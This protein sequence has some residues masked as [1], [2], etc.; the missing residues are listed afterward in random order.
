[1]NVMKKNKTVTQIPETPPQ[2]FPVKKYTAAAFLFFIIAGLIAA[3]PGS[4]VSPSFH[5][6][7]FPSKSIGYI[8]DGAVIPLADGDYNLFMPEQGTFVNG[9]APMMMIETGDGIFP[10]NIAD[11]S[12]LPR[13]GKMIPSRILFGF[14]SPHASNTLH[15]DEKKSGDAAADFQRRAFYYLHVKD[16][17]GHVERVYKS[18]H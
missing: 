16:G 11:D 17:F 7:I 15:Y 8:K 13:S 5:P 9:V 12:I 18:W 3:Y 4:G 2:P 1:M 14:T 6:E 10:L